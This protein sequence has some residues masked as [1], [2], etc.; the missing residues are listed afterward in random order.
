MDDRA[1]IAQLQRGD[2]AGLETL[3]R[4][5]QARAV[6]AAFLICRDAG[7]AEE[8]AQAAFLRAYERSN[9]FDP[10][11]PFGPWFLRSVVH[12]ALKAAAR[13]E[14]QV[15]WPDAAVSE[16]GAIIRAP[17]ESRGDHGPLVPRRTSGR[18]APGRGA[19]GRAPRS[20]PMA[21]HS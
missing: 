12:D 5:Y 15:P 14:R 8:I 21:G 20:G 7:L 1:A 10:A 13:R 4:R 19:A 9:Q 3:V 6:G 18:P 2:I 16:A 17:Y 11:R